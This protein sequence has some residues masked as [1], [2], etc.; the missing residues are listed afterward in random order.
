[1][2][3]ASEFKTVA[4]QIR[5]VEIDKP[6]WRDMP[7]GGGVRGAGVASGRG[8]LGLPAKA[9]DRILSDPTLNL[10]DHL[11]LACVSRAL[12]ACYYTPHAPTLAPFVCP[13]SALWAGLCALRP[14]PEYNAARRLVPESTAVT[15]EQ[16]QAVGRIWTNG[17]WVDARRMQVMKTVRVGGAGGG[18]GRKGGKKRKAEEMEQEYVQAVRSY[19]WERAIKLVHA[20]WI[21]KTDTKKLYK[22]TDTDLKC[23]KAQIK[24]NPYARKTGAPMQLFNE[25]AVESLA[26][27][28]HGGVRAHQALLDKRA[29]SAA[30][31]AATRQRNG[32][33][34]GRSKKTAFAP[35]EPDFSRMT[36]VEFYQWQLERMAKGYGYEGCEDEYTDCE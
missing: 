17:V 28:V 24:R 10:R 5:R 1:M 18:A 31:A 19:E 2:S 14:S 35:A 8:L 7:A 6:A 32:T 27:R 23:L 15:D 3:L 9:L 30:K 29:A 13:P 4:V 26:L 25:A 21:P 36:Q 12:R 34:S 22:L 16:R 33:S 20:L 11:S